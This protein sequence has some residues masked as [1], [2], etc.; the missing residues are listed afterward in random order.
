MKIG[1]LQVFKEGE[2]AYIA[3]YPKLQIYSYGRTIHEAISRLREIIKFYVESA[4]ELEISV[5][6]LCNV[7]PEEAFLQLDP[8]GL[9]G[10]GWIEIDVKN[11]LN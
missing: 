3:S 4:N 8:P 7:P 9:H 2:Q 11:N 1:L 6:E 5:E 10:E